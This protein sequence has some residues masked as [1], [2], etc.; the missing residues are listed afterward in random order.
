M[1]TALVKN[2][3]GTVNDRLLKQF[4]KNV[5]LINSFEPS[6][7]GLTDEELS[8]KTLLF[9]E[10]LNKGENLDDILPEAF[11]TVRE[12]AKRV[13]GLRHFDVQLIG[14]MVLHKGNIA[15]MRT[16]EGKTL[17]ATLAAY[18]N[19]LTDKGVHII[20]V[21]DYL[22][23]R[24]SEWMGEIFKF[25][26][27]TVGCITGGISEQERKEAYACHIT[28]G[29]NNEFGFDYLRD[30]MKF[31]QN[32][33]VQKPFNYAI[34]DE[35][36][37]ILIDEART[38]LIIS[39]PT[40]DNSE[41]YQKINDI[42]PKL[43]KE[44]YD[45][46]EEARSV[47]LTEEGTNKIEG[48]LASKSL[49]RSGQSLY[50]AENINLV[51]HINLSLR[52]HKLFTA[53]ID[54]LVRDN[55]VLIID[56]FTGRVM[57][58]RRYSEGLHQAI[59]AK[60][61]V[62]I[63]NENQTLASITFQNYFRLYPKLSGMTG[64]GITEASEFNDI[65]KLQV[66]EIPTNIKVA[67]I[68]EDDEIY[69]SEAEKFD[70]IVKMIEERNKV[71]Q[72][73]L[74][75]TVSIEK[76]EKLS[77]F[78]KKKKIVH[79]VLNAKYHEQE[80]NIISQAGRPY[81]VT[82]ATNMAG[83]GTDIVLG[84]NPEIEINNLRRNNTNNKSL[85][86]QELEINKRFE[87]DK[88]KVLAAGGLLVIGTERHESRRIDNQLRG[89]SG[90]QGDPGRTKF[91]LS[92]EDDLMR[93]FASERISVF[94]RKFGL[95]NGEP[96]FHPMLSKALEKAQRKVEGRNY[97]IRKA[98]LKYDDVMNDQRKVI[99]EQ[100]IEIIKAE[101]IN[102]IIKNMYLDIIDNLVSY[103]I[104]QKSYY[105]QWDI[106]GLSQ[107]LL[108]IFANNFTIE[109]FAQKEGIAEKEII[110]YLTKKVDDLFSA[111]EQKAEIE[112]INN[113]RKT[114]L[115]FTLDHLWKE[116]LHR[117]DHLRQ[118]INLRAYAQKDPL[119]E[120]KQ[121]AFEL[122]S[123]MLTSV[124]SKFIK[125]LFNT[126]FNYAN[127]DNLIN[128]KAINRGAKESRIDPAMLEAA[129]T[130]LESNAIISNNLKRNEDCP[131]GSGKKYKHCCGQE[132][133]INVKVSRNSPCVCGSGKKYKHCC[134]NMIE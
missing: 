74:V 49:I 88:Q 134:G 127:V 52:A 67:R 77:K 94:L 16:G 14:G 29:T 59:E 34:I 122:F 129:N 96:I 86:E 53:D 76:S 4:K 75:G 111:Q 85:E 63:Q 71:G 51:H 5:E 36:D 89:R 7:S 15:E 44:D 84:G 132:Q 78:L 9:K 25:L 41:L 57:D 42:I 118:G 55:K 39:G 8:K 98:L 100:R 38:P 11:A 56:E 108:D 12:S 22:A 133:R 120:Y 46:D 30:N 112:F 115:L 17:V 79:N 54:Y 18:L 60:E 50:D 103:Y 130:N 104:P 1:L 119:N 13:L 102:I 2:I 62:A 3:F 128:S 83:R 65:Y 24:D 97:E 33:F 37:S 123:L 92:L 113:I 6:I 95:K 28:Y 27:M 31:D 61:K 116:H 20:T 66:I 131:C 47:N 10:R 80:A 87:E 19:A 70:A 124:K 114:L 82:I 106:I 69:G 26:G 110:E 40:E 58:G 91:Y 45:I 121:E 125:Q 21:N 101:N 72:P 73:I 43:E 126:N 35:V 99:Y 32:Q 107:E 68:D 90:R 64:T 117:L 105:E 48:I 81:A 109:V 23:R 93:I